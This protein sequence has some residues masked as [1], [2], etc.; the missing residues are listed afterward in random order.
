MTRRQRHNR[1]LIGITILFVI[2]GFSLLI[3]QENGAFLIGC[4]L[5]TVF[6]LFYS[7]ACW[8]EVPK[9]IRRRPDRPA[10][11]KG[12]RLGSITANTARF[13]AEARVI[14]DQM[15]G[16]LRH[17]VFQVE[18][19]YPEGTWRCGIEVAGDRVLAIVN[20]YESIG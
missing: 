14:N 17:Q 2:G 5:Y 18:R 11:F 8:L 1:V 7:L 13:L 19:A 3:A 6:L 12:V 9:Q 10:E 20:S 15:F 16:N 4:C